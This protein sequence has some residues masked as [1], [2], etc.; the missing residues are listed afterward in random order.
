[1]KAEIRAISQ[2]TKSTAFPQYSVYS[3][4][5]HKR[6]SHGAVAVMS[7]RSVASKSNFPSHIPV[8]VESLA[9]AIEAFVVELH[10][11]VV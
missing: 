7:A 11:A 3:L 1:M 6:K 5:L 9:I 10:G 4:H 2:K 8:V